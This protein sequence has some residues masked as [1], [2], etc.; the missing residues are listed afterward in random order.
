MDVDRPE[1]VKGVEPVGGDGQDGE[2]ELSLA[3]MPMH[4]VAKAG[5]A[6]PDNNLL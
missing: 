2:V 4:T 6:T 1:E 3:M 5:D